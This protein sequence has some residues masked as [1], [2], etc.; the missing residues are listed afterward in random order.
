MRRD[1]PGDA[2]FLLALLAIVSIGATV[3]AAIMHHNNLGRAGRFEGD[4]SCRVPIARA[5]TTVNA[6]ACSVEVAH[7]AAHWVR[8]SRGSY[9]YR[10]ALR[11]GDGKLDSI[12]LKGDHRRAAW[13]ASPI[14]TA[15]LVRRYAELPSDT[16]RNVVSIQA[17]GV[18]VRTAWNPSWRNDDAAFGAMAFG[19]ISAVWL[20]A[21]TVSL[22]R[23]RHRGIAE[24]ALS[25]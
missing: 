3:A 4:D 19:F 12:E 11:T 14:G 13:E 21:L 5:D 6:G 2:A 9:Y 7:V 20:V 25:R 22:W 10:L 15:V 18:E 17:D 16:R 1:R 23:R 8:R 24:A